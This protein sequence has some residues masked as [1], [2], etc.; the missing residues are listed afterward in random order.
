MN[1][2][3]VISFLLACF[4]A[5]SAVQVVGSMIKRSRS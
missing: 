1:P 3:E 4:G 2:S 5:G